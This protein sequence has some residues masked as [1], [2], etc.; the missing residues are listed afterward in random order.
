[1]NLIYG[2]VDST[3][4]NN[5]QAKVD[6]VRWRYI[7]FYI[8][9][10]SI[11][12]SIQVSAI[13]HVSLCGNLYCAQSSRGQWGGSYG[14]RLCKASGVHPSF[15]RQQESLFFLP[16]FSC[17]SWDV[18]PPRSSWWPAAQGIFSILCIRAAAAWQSTKLARGHERKHNPV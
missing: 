5:L 7:T 14:C 13:E 10:C 6:P 18:P 11:I 16:G 3:C 15:S 8:T 1:M 17:R 4:K 2:Y 12:G 9:V